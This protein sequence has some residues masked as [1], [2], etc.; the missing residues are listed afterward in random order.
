MAAIDQENVEQAVVI[1]IKQR[2]AAAHRFDQVF[3]R[4]GGIHM[5]EIEAAGMFYVKESLR[6]GQRQAHE[7]PEIRGNRGV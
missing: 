6:H 2:Y 1:V 7:R 3:L 4:R 5:L